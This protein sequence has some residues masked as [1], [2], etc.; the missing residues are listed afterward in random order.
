[1]ESLL[2]SAAYKNGSEE[3]QAHLRVGL[4]IYKVVSLSLQSNWEFLVMP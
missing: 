4:E 2:V 1:M 3:Q